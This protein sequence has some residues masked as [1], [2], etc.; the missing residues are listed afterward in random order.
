MFMFRCRRKDSGRYILNMLKYQLIVCFGSPYRNEIQKSK[1][2]E[3]K[4]C[5]RMATDI[6]LYAA[7]VSKVV[8]GG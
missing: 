5:R 4:A 8:E 3:M 6:F 2:E 1:M 7:N